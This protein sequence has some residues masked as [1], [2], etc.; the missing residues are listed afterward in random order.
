MYPRIDIAYNGTVKEGKDINGYPNDE[1]KSKVVEKKGGEKPP[2]IQEGNEVFMKITRN[3]KGK[4]MPRYEKAKVIG[5]IDRNIVPVKLGKR[6]TKVVIK[7]VKRPP[8]VASSLDT[9]GPSGISKQRKPARYESE[10]GNSAVTDKYSKIEKYHRLVYTVGKDNLMKL[11]STIVLKSYSDNNKLVFVLEVP[12]LDTITYNYYKIIPIP[13]YNPISLKTSVIIPEYPYLI[14]NGLK[15]RPVSTP[16]QQIENDREDNIVQYADTTCIEQIML[17]KNYSSCHKNV[18]Q[19]EDL[20]NHLVANRMSLLFTKKNIILTETCKEEARKYNLKGTFLVIPNE[21]CETQ[22]GDKIISKVAETRTTEVKLLLN[23]V[24]MPELQQE[25][26]IEDSQ[27]DLRGVDLN[28]IKDILNSAKYNTFVIV[29]LKLFKKI[30]QI[31]R[32]HLE[33]KDSSPADF[34]LKGGGVK[35]ANP[36]DLCFIQQVFKY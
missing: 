9:P 14:V 1:N 30:L 2:E 27:V 29:K 13:I 16:C 8:Q 32:N 7:N 25:I 33:P 3:R 12:L 6:N 31:R 28:D 26:R 4:E 15:Y 18:V 34:S 11:E 21:S 19:I 23:P 24:T 36:I 10:S 17:L 20:K 22:I 5:K 35:G